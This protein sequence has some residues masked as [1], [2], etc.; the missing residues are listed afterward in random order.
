MLT[1]LGGLAGSSPRN[2]P[3]QIFSWP[4]PSSHSALGVADPSESLP[5]HSFHRPLVLQHVYPAYPPGT[6]LHF[7][8]STARVTTFLTHLSTADPPNR[9]TGSMSVTGPEPAILQHRGGSCLN[10]RSVLTQARRHPR[11]GARHPFLHDRWPLPGKP[12]PPPFRGPLHD[13]RQ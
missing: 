12:S 5:A 1:L 3:L 9:R 6:L 2:N 10:K 8:F 13:G 4:D 7:T 11:Q